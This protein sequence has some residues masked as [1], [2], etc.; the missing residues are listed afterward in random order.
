MQQNKQN[1]P[2]TTIDLQQGESLI[3]ISE[4]SVT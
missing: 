3:E 1:T 4:E 2:A